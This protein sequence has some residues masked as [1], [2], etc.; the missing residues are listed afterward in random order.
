MKRNSRWLA[1]ILLV[2]GLVGSVEAQKKPA[3]TTVQK[4]PAS[5][6]PSKQPADAAADE[7]K[8]R[9]IVAFLEY[10]LNTLGS[11]GTPTRDKEVL[12]TE[13]YAKIFRDSKVQIED[14]LDEERV[15]ITNK[16]IV[17]YLKD[18]N[19]FFSN[20]RFEFTIENIHTS[21]L[22]N[23]DLFYKVTTR[24][25]LKGTTIS[26]KPINNTVPRYIEINFNPKEQD[27]KIV[28]LYTNG[29]DEKR[30]LTG[31]WKELTLEWQAIFRQKLN[32]KDSVRLNDI[33]AITAIES[34]DLSGNKF[35]R[36][37]APIGL[38]TNL[39]S[40]NLSGTN[41]VDLAPVRDLT[42]L[43]E[44][45]LS[46]TKITN[47]NPLRYSNKL[48]VVMLHD[49]D[50]SDITIV[51]KMPALI[52]LDL[53]ESPVSDI[54]ALADLTHLTKLNLGGTR[55]SSLQS[56]ERLVELTDLNLVRTATQDVTPLK[57]L[58]NLRALNLDSTQVK[59]LSALSGMESLSILQI[60]FTS[61]SNLSPLQGLQHLEKIYCDQTPI[62][63][64][65][66]DAFMAT[67][68]TVLVIFD[69]N[70]L[71]SWWETLTPGWQTILSQ[72]ASIKKNPSKDELALVPLLDSINLQGQTNLRDLEP[73]RKL[74]RLRV[75]KIN[76]TEIT[77][78]QPLVHHKE[79]TYLDIGE[80][81]VRDITV[82]SQFKK[83]SLLKADGA[84]IENLEVM[85][86]PS[87]K[88]VYANRTPVNDETAR[89]FLKKNQ[90]CLLV[91]KTDRLTRWWETLGTEW[92]E[93]LRKQM[94]PQ[95]Q[96]TPEAL[97]VL[98]E[99]NSMIIQDAAITNLAGLQ[100]FIALRE[101]TVSG[102]AM[103]LIA[104][105]RYLSSL[106]VLRVTNSP[107]REID[108][109]ALLSELEELDISN[110]P[111]FDIFPVWKLKNLKTLNCSG[112]QI[113]RL[114][115]LEKLEH[116]E[117]LDC[118]NTNVTKLDALDY[119]PLK[120]LKCYNTKVSQ[121]A[122]QNFQGAHP[123]CNVMY[124]R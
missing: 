74:P 62:K 68:P 55:I 60:N 9:D 76:K 17:A 105:V 121:R 10:M 48:E 52:F 110:T 98:I 41:V 77:S 15:V 31:W 103:S 89:E 8:V 72:A 80:T 85:T 20:V 82:I 36:N 61:V 115:M 18:V 91:Y 29:V 119:L 118:S 94:E 95:G 58:K 114:D 4:T 116:L 16:D 27:L 5:G 47:L 69:S 19:F 26:G 100:E 70:D 117:Y 67:N 84:P 22:P 35:I 63:R 73:L 46:H 33:K 111:L 24:R 123:K 107:I 59:D 12:I 28:S 50:V 39:K 64:E 88:I 45:N 53:S 3:K 124:Y 86:M 99:R 40:L 51:E 13:S 101:L 43:K 6:T 38:L 37:I 81:G 83:L 108:S 7:K 97:H 92:K 122:I 113:K 2:G 44:L 87:L 54:S 66:A 23:G 21:T 71:K 75:I 102:T 106:K 30:S 49:T 96:V 109:L 42:E 79:I 120:T 90:K 32:L 25:N 93:I 57:S 112:T 11:S 104:P 78:L 34:L 14:D 1:M 56:L 65:A